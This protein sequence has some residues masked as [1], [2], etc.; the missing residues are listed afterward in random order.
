MERCWYDR[1]AVAKIEDDEKRDF[2]RTIIAD[3]KPMFMIYIYPTLANEYKT[4]LTSTNKNSLREFGVTV[5]ELKE[6]R[7]DELTPR[8]IE[9]LRYYDKMMPVGLNDCVMNRICRIFEREFDDFIKNKS[10]TNAEFDP[11]ILKSGISYTDKDYKVVRNL[12]NDYLNRLKNYK[13]RACYERVD[14][15]EFNEQLDRIKAEFEEECDKVCPCRRTLTDILID[16]CYSNASTKRYI[17]SSCGNIVVDNLLKNNDNTLRFPELCAE[18]E[19]EYGGKRFTIK[20][21]KVE[22]EE[23]DSAE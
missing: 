14:G 10:G 1:H 11:E 4:Y 5:E 23:N 21:K 17:W 9:F 18:G 20:E 13:T 12:H 8:Q 3:K 22:G 16:I 6:K 7:Y 2:Y 19:F 15:D